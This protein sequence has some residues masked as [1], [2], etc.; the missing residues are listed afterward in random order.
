MKY[1]TKV[2][3]LSILK[4]I[5]NS[6][7]IVYSVLLISM[8]LIGGFKIQFL[9]LS[10]SANSPTQIISIIF[11]FAIIRISVGIG[12]QNALLL[13]IAL[14]VGLIITEGFLRLVDLPIASQPKLAQWRQPSN[15]LG[16]ELVPFLKGKGNLGTYIE[17]N[18]HGLRDV[19]RPWEKP[20][21]K[22]RILTL[23]DSFTYGDGVELKETYSKQLEYL[24]DADGIQ[25]DAINAGVIG[26]NLFQCLTY[27]KTRGVKYHPDLV[28]Y[29]F[30]VDDIGGSNTVEKILNIK[31]KLVEAEKMSYD[32]DGNS[33]FY[34]VNLVKNTNVLIERLLRPLTTA[35][36]LKSIDERQNHLKVLHDSRLSNQEDLLIF[37]Q[38]LNELKTFSNNIP[39][40]LLVVL[41]P[42]AVQLNNPPVQKVNE[43][44]RQYCSEIQI[45]LLDITEI[46]ENHKDIASLY[47]FPL[48]AHTSAKGNNIISNE[49]YKRI[50]SEGFITN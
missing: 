16:W 21:E 1:I 13:W 10:I 7:L 2:P 44:L 6:V 25:V 19:E 43:T 20:E 46:F 31:E 47:H 42:D 23:G 36:W 38:H 32:Q 39:A 17:I 14:I 15:S 24:L 45:P 3:T 49:V 33:N 40:K 18:S 22:Y 26:Y 34:I 29:F 4:W 9:G 8:I 50:Y 11:I 12:P 37:K 5:L 30:W 28:I 48:D 35:K 41:I 27:L